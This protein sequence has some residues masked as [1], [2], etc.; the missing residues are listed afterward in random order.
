MSQLRLVAS[1]SGFHSLCLLSD[2][3][4]LVKTINTIRVMMSK[5]DNK[6][7]N[8]LYDELDRLYDEASYIRQY[9]KTV[10]GRDRYLV[11]QEIEEEIIYIKM[12]IEEIAI[13]QSDYTDDEL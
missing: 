10:D 6:L 3:H 1:S 4:I 5:Y 2:V 12:R 7:L 13:I 11:L 9:H 8:E